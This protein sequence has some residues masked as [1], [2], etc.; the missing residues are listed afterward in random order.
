MNLIQIPFYLQILLLLGLLHPFLCLIL[1]LL[2]L[3][4]LSAAQLESAVVLFFLIVLLEGHGVQKIYK[5]LDIMY[6]LYIL[7]I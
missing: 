6:I 4:H 3:L 5:M 2:L 7:Y 1:H